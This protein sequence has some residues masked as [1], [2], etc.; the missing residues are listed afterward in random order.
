MRDLREL[1]HPSRRVPLLPPRDG[2]PLH[3][4]PGRHHLHLRRNHSTPAQEE[5]RICR[6]RGAIQEGRG[7]RRRSQQRPEFQL[8]RFRQTPAGQEEDGASAEG[9]G[10]RGKRRRRRDGDR[11][12]KKLFVSLK[13]QNTPILSLV[14]LVVLLPPVGSW[15]PLYDGR[16]WAGRRSIH[17]AQPLQEKQRV[18]QQQ[19][20]RRRCPHRRKRHHPLGHPPQ[21][22][23]RHGRE[24]QAQ[25]Y[26]DH[27][28]AG[29]GLSRMLDSLLRHVYVVS[30][31]KAASTCVC[32][33]SV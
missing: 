3:P 7:R 29:G 19:F 22:R 1:H 20:G 26:Q 13:A 9:S 4:P 31:K 33:H 16:G 8:G 23:P 11:E 30:E 27:P 21:V 2:L 6:G 15:P 14:F 28:D 18:G 5:G 12:G 17:P 25:H 24:G 10:R 32:L